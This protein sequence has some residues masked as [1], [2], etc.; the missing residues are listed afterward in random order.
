MLRGVLD[1]FFTM[2]EQDPSV[3][4][5]LEESEDPGQQDEGSAGQ[6]RR[7]RHP[8]LEANIAAQQAAPEAPV[9]EYDVPAVEDPPQQTPQLPAS[10]D[11]GGDLVL[12][13][14][15]PDPSEPEQRYE[16]GGRLR[17]PNEADEAFQ[18]S[19]AEV[20]K[21]RQ[22]AIEA[23]ATARAKEE[24]AQTLL[25]QSGVGQAAE[26]E[27]DPFRERLEDAG[28]PPAELDSYLD[29][30][31]EQTFANMGESL[32]QQREAQ[33]QAEQN[34]A[35]THEGFARGKLEAFMEGRPE[36]K[37]AYEAAVAANLESGLALG[38]ELMS[39]SEKGVTEPAEQTPAAKVPPAPG[40]R[41]AIPPTQQKVGTPAPGNTKADQQKLNQQAEQDG[42]DTEA[43][44]RALRNRFG[45]SLHPGLTTE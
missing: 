16:I 20:E 9:E 41:R 27:S 42:W 29:R 8:A 40:A 22:K 30:R 33:T 21:W 32:T 18:H 38:W 5:A 10:G 1:R 26:P 3:D 25:Q 13:A 4:A 6:P 39:A 36:L 23:E 12:P 45:G 44:K 31:L 17:T 15:E 14:G 7:F 28:I 24:L 37:P 34:V 19:R 43:G 35:N 2:Y 11:E